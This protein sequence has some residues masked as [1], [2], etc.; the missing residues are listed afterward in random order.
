MNMKN[1]ICIGDIK[2]NMAKIHSAGLCQEVEMK[3]RRKSFK[4]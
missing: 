1:E 2:V 4:W 3:T